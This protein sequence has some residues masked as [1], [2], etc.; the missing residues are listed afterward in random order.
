M[1]G[2]IVTCKEVGSRVVLSKRLKHIPV[3][4]CLHKWLYLLLRAGRSLS[5]Q[6]T[7]IVEKGGESSPAAG[8]GEEA[9]SLGDEGHAH[10]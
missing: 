3:C 9:Q 4:D 2:R 5:N 1:I 10:P 8:A 6:L 7:T